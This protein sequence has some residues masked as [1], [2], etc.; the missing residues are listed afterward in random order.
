MFGQRLKELR[1]AAGYSQTRLAE[2]L[3]ISQQAVGKWE[4]GRATPD[5]NTIATIA[6]LLGVSA[7]T[8]LGTAGTGGMEA[9]VPV[10]GSV[11]AGYGALAFEEDYG[12]EPANVRDPENYLYLIVKGDSMEPRIFDG[13]YAL[14]HKQNTLENGDLGVLIYGDEEA[15]LKRYIR[16]GNAVI[17]EPFNPDY[18]PLVIEGE[19]LEHLHIVGKVRETRTKW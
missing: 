18:E 13:D 7:D 14:V 3:G 9:L 10:V 6:R 8:M 12:T 15:T 16:R 5:P 19:A 4:T 17:L 11:R 1:K 2:Y